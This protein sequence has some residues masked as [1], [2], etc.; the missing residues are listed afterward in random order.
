MYFPVHLLTFN[1]KFKRNQGYITLFSHV[2]H[3][4]SLYQFDKVTL[5]YK[6][7]C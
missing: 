3:S 7:I 5:N 1:L 4:I 6:G 2:I